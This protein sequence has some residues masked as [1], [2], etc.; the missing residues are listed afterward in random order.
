MSSQYCV[1]MHT[2]P[3]EKRYIGI[4]EKSPEK[5]WRNGT[6]YSNNRQFM[7]AIKKYGWAN[8]R[9][10]VLFSDLSKESAQRIEQLLI[11]VY[12]SA[13]PN[14]GYNRTLGGESASGWVHTEDEKL[15]MSESHKGEKNHFYGKNHTDESLEKMRKASLGNNNWLGRKHSEESKEKIRQARIGVSSR[16]GWKMTQEQKDKISEKRKAL[17]KNE[18]FIKLMRE[19][20]RNKKTVYQYTLGG[21]LV[22]TW[23]SRH[24]AENDFIS[25]R[26]SLAIGKCC[27]GNCKSAYGYI[28]SYAPVQSEVG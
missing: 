19:A 1:Y 7:N 15:R 8:F 16:S 26:K 10:E 18:S 2:S 3:N 6:G 25:G 13:D 20:S 11:F 27:Q 23:D 22:Q 12:K 17:C 9:H 14:N 28:W 4:T 21:D 24:H 5:R